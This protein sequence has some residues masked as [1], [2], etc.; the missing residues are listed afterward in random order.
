MGISDFE[1]IEE[2][3]KGSYSTVYK[4]ERKLDGQFYALKK[5]KFGS[6][7][8]RDKQNALNEIRILASLNHPNIVTYKEAFIDEGTSTLCLIMEYAE[9]GDLLQSI[10]NHKKNN[11]RFTEEEIWKI[12]NQALKGLK[13]LH[14]LNILHRD[15]KS[16][17]M[18]ILGDSSVQLGD[19]NVSKVSYGL[20]HTQTGTPY[21]ASP[22]I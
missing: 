21:Y 16:A 20:A 7:T 6:M 11:T 3:G 22:E 12:T 15:I 5:I 18:F 1:F 4:V 8:T 14:D 9:K 10:Q 19:L 2:L 17:N 13:A